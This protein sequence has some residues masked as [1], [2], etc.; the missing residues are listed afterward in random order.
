MSY[1]MRPVRSIRP[2]APYVGGKKILARTLAERIAAIPH[3]T[4]CEPFVGMGGVFLRRAE[5]AGTEAINDRSRDVATLFRVVQRHY[6]AFLDM[7]RWQLASRAEFERLR[8]QDPET[9]TDLERAARFLYLQRNAFGGKVDGR[10]FGIATG[11]PARFD[12]RRLG[13]QLEALHERLSGVWIEC[14]P[15]AEFLRRWDR[16]ATLFYLDPPYHG[17]E[18]DYGRGLFGRGEFAALAAA[19]RCLRGRFI[20]TLNDVPETRELF[21]W[22]SIEPVEL[23]YF[24]PGRGGQAGAREL[25]ITGPERVS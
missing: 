4:Y 16:P 1:E 14:L 13:P 5:R 20:L 9:L 3:A 24:L 22:A 8:G 25:I 17:C 11:Q 6:Q 18:D 23:T 19:L 7:M 12:M 2:V 21:G 10:S 15:W